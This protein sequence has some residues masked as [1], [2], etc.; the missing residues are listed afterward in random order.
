[1]YHLIWHCE[2]MTNRLLGKRLG[3]IKYILQT[4]NNHSM[5]KLA[6]LIESNA[7]RGRPTWRARET[8]TSLDQTIWQQQLLLKR[9]K[10]K[11]IC[12]LAL[13]HVFIFK[14]WDKKFTCGHTSS[15][16]HGCLLA[17]HTMQ[18]TCHFNSL[19]LDAPWRPLRINVK[20]MPAYWGEFETQSRCCRVVL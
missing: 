12:P 7:I 18:P 9:K 13:Q 16:H 8:T 1:M 15:K 10:K 4:L 17:Q 11:N 19:K 5:S 2:V 20:Y 14:V 6:G 3:I